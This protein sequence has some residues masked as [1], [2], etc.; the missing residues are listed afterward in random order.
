MA[1][2]EFLSPD[3]I[4]AAREVYERSLDIEGPAPAL[5]SM[6]LVIDDV[7]FDS[8]PTIDAHLDT[9]NGRTEIELGHLERADVKVTMGYETAKALFVDGDAEAGVQAF[10]QGKIRVEGDMSKLLA[11]QSAPTG[12]REAMIGD[13]L[14]AI[15]K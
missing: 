10:M 3:W 14:R 11:Y 4:K 6:N 2:H 12:E 15:T 13:G 9:T 7:P 1:K 8:N 5:I